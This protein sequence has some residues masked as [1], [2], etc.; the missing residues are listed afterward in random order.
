M[1]EHVFEEDNAIG[2]RGEDIFES[3][4]SGIGIDFVR[5]TEDPAWQDKDVDFVVFGDDGVEYLYEI[6]NDTKISRT[7]NVFYEDVS[8]VEYG[9]PGCF[10]KTEADYIVVCSEPNRTMYFLDARALRGFVERNES[11]FRRISV[12]DGSHSSGL[13][14]PLS[15]LRGISKKVVY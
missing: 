1:K 11:A 3:F 7:G 13:L 8:N 2:A 6:K 15:A 14:V 5:V 4:C 9:T 10:K 12:V